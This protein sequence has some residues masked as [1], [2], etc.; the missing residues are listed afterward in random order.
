MRITS[1]INLCLVNQGS[2]VRFPASPS[3]SDE[4]FSRC[5]VFWDALKPEQLPVE[6]SGIPGHKNHKKHKPTRP[7]LVIA[8]EHGHTQENYVSGSI[9][10]VNQGARVWFLASPSLSDETWKPWTRFLRRFKIRTNA[11]WA[12]AQS[13]SNLGPL[14]ARHSSETPFRWRFAS[15]PIVAR[16]IVLT[17]R[18]LLDIKT[19][20]PFRQ[21]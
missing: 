12:F 4:T 9:C 18:E 5:P 1:R 14:S 7:V 15:G 2:Q 3:L 6:P 16:L 11:G 21:Y 19:I 17:G 8:K 10:L 13:S 20:H